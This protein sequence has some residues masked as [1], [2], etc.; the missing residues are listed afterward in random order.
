MAKILIVDDDSTFRE[1][2]QGLL[3]EDGHEPVL[4]ESGIEAIQTFNNVKPDVVL[5]DMLMPKMSGFDCADALRGTPLGQ[6]TPIIFVSGAYKSPKTIAEAQERFSPYAYLLKPFSAAELSS[7]INGA[8]GVAMGDEQAGVAAAADPLPESGALLELSVAH[9]LYRVHHEKQTGILEIYGEPDRARL[10]FFRGNA[11]Q[12]QTSRPELNV[13]MLLTRSGQLSPYDYKA[14]LEHVENQAVGLYQALRDFK[15]VADT[16]IKEAYRRLVPEIMAS[17]VALTGHFRWYATD[18]FMRLIPTASVAIPP[19]IVKG[20]IDAPAELLLAHLEPRRTL[21]MTKGPLWQSGKAYLTD[22]LGYDDVLKQVNGRTRI[23]QVYGAA[24]NELK[25]QQ[26]MAQL[27]LLIASNAVE[28][29]EEKIEVEPSIVVPDASQVQLGAQEVEIDEAKFADLGSAAAAM[30]GPATH[31]AEAFD[32]DP[33]AD[34]HMDAGIEFTPEE[35]EARKKIIEKFKSIKELDYYAVLDVKQ[36]AFQAGSAKQ[37]YFKLAREFHSDSYS[38][39]NLGS[40]QR[41]L[42]SVFS[43][44]SEA[45]ETLMSDDKRGEYDAQLDLEAKGITADVATIFKAEGLLDKAMI[46]ADRGDFTSALRN[47]EE[48]M[49]IYPSQQTE[50]WHIYCGFRA[51]GNQPSEANQAIL[52]ITEILKKARV[53]RAYE[54][55]GVIYRF[56]DDYAKAKRMFRRALDE[57][58]NTPTVERE[59]RLIAKRSQ[60][61]QKKGFAGKL[62]NK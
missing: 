37:N 36:Q 56:I 52:R 59:L 6:R 53:E 55:M 51:R 18:A 23:A 46:L 11:V 19:A 7:S 48:A 2:V 4:A 33:D 12:A 50:V 38:G 34:S 61:P 41:K 15:T 3:L 62:F 40:A 26:R 43:K 17:C 28:L 47:L 30:G 27:F 5:L 60:Q 24:P 29:A 44:I 25:K 54:F 58:G 45:Y 21:R 57:D 22:G 39:M 20:V 13:A 42:E 35:Q 14:L 1:T 49:A 31:M 9:L 32:Y 16:T 10:F 8:L